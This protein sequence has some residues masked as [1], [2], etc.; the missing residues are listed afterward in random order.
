MKNIFKALTQ[1]RE[2]VTKA[3]NILTKNKVASASIDE[4]EQLL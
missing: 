3:F 1:T 2:K 4:L